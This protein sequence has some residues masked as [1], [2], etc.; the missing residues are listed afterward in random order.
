MVLGVGGA[1][2]TDPACHSFW[3]PPGLIPCAASHFS[4]FES[5]AP[6]AWVAAEAL[7]DRAFIQASDAGNG[8]LGVPLQ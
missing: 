3:M 1:S 6:P 4:I 8:P 2:L 7:S 5:S